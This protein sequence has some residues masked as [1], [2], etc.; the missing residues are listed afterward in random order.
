M[1][2]YPKP[3]Q[4]IINVWPVPDPVGLP[5]LRRSSNHAGPGEQQRVALHVHPGLRCDGRGAPLRGGDQQ[6]PGEHRPQG[7]TA[8]P[9]GGHH[10]HAGRR[11]DAPHPHAGHPVLH[12]L[13]RQA[14]QEAVHA[15]LGGGAQ[16][17]G[18]DLRGEA[19]GPAGRGAGAGP[20]APPG[21]DP[22]V[23]RPHERP[24]PPQRVRPGVDAPLPV[25]GE[26]RGDPGTPRPQHQ[27]VPGA[28]PPLR[29]EER[30]PQHLPCA[31]APRG[32][33][34]P[35]R[36]RAHRRHAGPGDRRGRA[37]ECLPDALQRER[38]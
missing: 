13:R 9:Q 11:A 21:D 26:R 27:G 20:E 30:G 1:R 15:L 32:D 37:A 24:E 36:S 33:A 12:Q 16:V 17:P 38:G 31:Q 22:G 23:Q 35:R 8:R 2:G 34:D 29:A 25:Q 28:P 4:H 6:G 14:P 19:R 5:R 18:A 10:G 7:Q 3:A